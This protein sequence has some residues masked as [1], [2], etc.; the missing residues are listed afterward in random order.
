MIKA[1]CAKPG[2]KKPA[3]YYGQVIWRKEGHTDY[4]DGYYCEPDA[5]SLPEP[6]DKLDRERVVIETEIRPLPA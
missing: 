2:C 5:R 4:F 3:T 1:L 6:G